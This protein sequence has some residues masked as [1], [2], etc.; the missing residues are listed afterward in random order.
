M[1]LHF[2]RAEFD[3]RVAA[4]RAALRREDL[5]AILLFAQESHFYLTGFDT[6][7][8]VSEASGENVFIVRDGVLKTP[9]VET[10]L[11]GITRRTVMDLARKRNIEIIERAIFPEELHRA[12]EVFLTGS[13]FGICGVSQVG[14]VGL[15]CPG[16][17]TSR[18]QTAW[19]DF[20]GEPVDASFR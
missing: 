20:S 1:A 9:P 14:Q 7:G 4:A 13:A 16:P 8:F 15:P 12:Q 10:V 18:L 2:E 17:W 6:S 3:A 19:A 11:D 5:A